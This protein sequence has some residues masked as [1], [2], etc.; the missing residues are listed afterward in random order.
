M[1]RVAVIGA[2]V[3]GLAAAAHLATWADV[4]V[5]EKS[6]GLGGRVA[7]RRAD[8]YAFNHGA[9]YF[10]ARDPRFA[11]RV[12]A[13]AAAGVVQPW[14]A[15]RA[16]LDRETGRSELLAGDGQDRWVGAPRMTSIG[17][18]LA[19]GLGVRRESRVTALRLRDARWELELEGGAVHGPYDW[20]VVAIPAPQAAALLPESSPLHGLARTAV[21]LATFALMLGLE[22]P[23]RVEWDA[24]RVRNSPLSWVS[25][26]D[27]SSAP[28]L[29]AHA[30]HAWSRENLEV[31]IEALEPQLVSEALQLVG[32]EPR[33]VRHSALHRW[34]Y[35]ACE[36]LTMTSRL[37][38]ARRLAVCGDWT[39]GSRVE[40]AYLSG[41]ELA[42]ELAAWPAT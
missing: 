7:T 9:P 34:R 25:L 12:R 28:T 38:L 39:R 22:H 31:P 4:T 19:E 17:R 42:E 10:T 14:R 36:P 37:D 21:M 41:L 13:L 26:S 23:P 3:A 33:E 6:R 2:G 11:L 32:L 29:V 40:D 18:A 16:E 30:T 15:R 24:A 20:V 5:F 8:P 35:A 1:T 27:A